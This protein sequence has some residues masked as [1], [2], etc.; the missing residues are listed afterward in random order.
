MGF[1]PSDTKGFPG[2]RVDPK[3]EGIT[4]ITCGS[5]TEAACLEPLVPDLRPA[6]AKLSIRNLA[7]M[8][9]RILAHAPKPR[10]ARLSNQLPAGVS[11]LPVTN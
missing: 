10:Q 8:L 9:A 5:L 11:S 7:G 6:L 1:P 3:R 2:S 4:T